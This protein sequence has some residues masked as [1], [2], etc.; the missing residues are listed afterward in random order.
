MNLQHADTNSVEYPCHLCK[1]VFT[2]KSSL[3]NHIHF[4]HNRKNNQNEKRQI[5][6]TV[7]QMST[8]ENMSN[9]KI[10]KK[11]SNMNYCSICNVPFL[12]P[13]GLTNHMKRSH[14]SNKFEGEFSNKGA[15][16]QIQHSNGT[17]L[18]K[19]PCHLCKSSF[20]KES[21]L[22]K[23]VQQFHLIGAVQDP[24]AGTFTVCDIK[25]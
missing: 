10:D 4:F 13:R 17:P 20:H 5:L 22:N 6:Q 23:H 8:T 12:T 3:L 11:P 25:S 18:Q 21:A 1:N 19:W 16:I 7:T 9:N 15:N 14:Q 2:V 24:L